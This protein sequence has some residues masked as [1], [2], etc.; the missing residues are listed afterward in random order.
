MAWNFTRWWLYVVGPVAGA[1][2]AVMVIGVLRGLP[3][4]AERGAAEGDA[5]PLES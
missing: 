1:T 5:L 4:P 2:I 3:G